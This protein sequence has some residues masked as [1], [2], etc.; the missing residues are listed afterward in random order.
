VSAHQGIE[1]ET[2]AGPIETVVALVAAV[3]AVV[4]VYMLAAQT[5]APNLPFPGKI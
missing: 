3:V 2:E 1:E 5:I 4:L